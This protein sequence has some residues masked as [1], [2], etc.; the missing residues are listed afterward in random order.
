MHEKVY[1]MNHSVLMHFALDIG[2][3]MMA[4]GAETYRVEDT[5]SRILTAGNGTQLECFVTPTGIFASWVAAD[6]AHNAYI[7]R[8][9]S[10]SINLNKIEIANEISRQFCNGKV[11]LDESIE[12]LNNTSN[13]NGYKRLIRLISISLAA[14]LF[15]IVLGG[16]LI[17]FLITLA[18]GIVLVL[19]QMP[20]SGKGISN[21]FIDL[22]G[23]FTATMTAMFLLHICGFD[24]NQGIIITSALMPMVPG[25]AITNAIRDTLYGHLV[26][27]GARILDAFIIAA[28]IA[29]G[30]GIALFMF[31]MIIGGGLL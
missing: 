27:G 25:V 6:G 18:A 24:G 28:S 3:L 15:A 17:D 23:G 7:R 9:E 30:V 21:F 4:S 22:I 16:S 19:I 5:M 1:I 12:A 14:A 10:R 29:T 26:S 8:I 31:D 13:E 2:E 11:S 20:L